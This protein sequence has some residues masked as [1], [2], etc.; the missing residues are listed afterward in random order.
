MARVDKSKKLRP[1]IL[2]RLLD[3]DPHNQTEQD[4]SAPVDK[5]IA[6]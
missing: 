2:D 6:Q 3:D 4:R 1:S 5:A